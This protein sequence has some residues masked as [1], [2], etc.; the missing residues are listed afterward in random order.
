M[1]DNQSTLIVRRVGGL[2]RRSVQPSLAV[3]VDG[4]PV[5]SIGEKIAVKSG[6]LNVKVSTFLFTCRPLQ[7]EVRD[8]AT[9]ELEYQSSWL[10]W[11]FVV[12]G[13]FLYLVLALPASLLLEQ[14]EWLLEGDMLPPSIGFLLLFAGLALYGWLAFLAPPRILASFG[15]HSHKIQTSDSAE[16]I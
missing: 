3:M 5:G 11:F 12:F 2:V 7:V 15:V 1:N 13:F 4:K 8:G 14:L 9:V 10:S 16:Q 6:V